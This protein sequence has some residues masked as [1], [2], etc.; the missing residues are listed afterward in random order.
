MC[1]TDNAE[2]Q[3]AVKKGDKNIKHRYSIRIGCKKSTGSIKEH[4]TSCLSKLTS[5]T[6][7]VWQLLEILIWK[8]D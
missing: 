6:Y 2:K 5:E 8:I 1:T 3:E 7:L 4:V